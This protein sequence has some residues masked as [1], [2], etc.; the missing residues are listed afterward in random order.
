MQDTRTYNM[1]ITNIHHVKTDRKDAANIAKCLAFRT[2]SEVYVPNDEDNKIKEYIRVRDDQKLW[3]KKIKQQILAFVLR[4]GK[5]YEGGKAYWTITHEKWLKAL[6]LEGLAK[7]TLAE[8]LI[9]Y[10]YLKDKIERLDTRISEL[11]S[12]TNIGTRWPL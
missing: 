5:H 9:T 1:G 7:E 3:L 4:Q 6:D 8:Y 10:A 11:A 12:K 2:Y